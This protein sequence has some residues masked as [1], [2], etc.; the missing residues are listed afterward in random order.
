MAYTRNQ[1]LGLFGA[2]PQAIMEQERQKQAQLLQS[3]RNPYQQAGTAIG[4]ALGRLFGGESQA[5]QQARQLQDLSKGFDFNTVEGMQ[6]AAQALQDAGFPDRA[7]Q[8]LDMAQRRATSEQ[9]RTLQGQRTVNKKVKVVMR[10]TDPLTGDPRQ[11]E[12][13]VDVP[14]VIDLANPDAPPRPIFGEDY[15]QELAKQ[16]LALEAQTE[17]KSTKEAAKP[18][19]RVLSEMAEESANIPIGGIYTRKS[20]GKMFRR[21]P[22]P[23]GWE[24][25]TPQQID[26]EAGITQNQMRGF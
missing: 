17:T 8:L 11:K 13:F 20:D 22:L 4:M 12:V 25:I 3:M 24:E 9:T 18:E 10:T 7:M 5:V 23:K 16:Q 19:E 2:S 21:V 26:E 6:T 15:A 1:V 14:H